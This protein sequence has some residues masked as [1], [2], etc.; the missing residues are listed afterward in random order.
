M[1]LEETTYAKVISGNAKQFP[2]RVAV[3][4]GNTSYTYKELDRI[5]DV[6]AAKIMAMGIEKGDHVALWGYN[7]ANWYLTFVSIIKAGA[8]AVL[9]NYSL[10]VKD[11]AEL[12]SYTDSKFI[13][14]GNNR[15][16]S[17]DLDAAKNLAKLS[18]LSEDKLF[19][20]ADETLDFKK[21]IN[22]DVDV[23]KVTAITQT[24]DT[25]R[26]AV[27]IFTTGTTAT[28]KAVLLSQYGII[29]DGVSYGGKYKEDRGESICNTLP[30]F[31]SF[32]LMVVSLYTHDGRTVY[33]HELIKP[34]EIVKV[35]STYKTPDIA[36]VGAVYTALVEHPEFDI[37]VI[38]YA[39]ICL[40]GGSVSTP[41][42][43]M[44]LEDKFTHAVF[45]NAYG[46]TE[47][48]PAVTNSSPTDPIEKR[49]ASVGSVLEG[50]EVKIWD[51]EKGILKTG[52]VGE[53]VIRGFVVMNGYYK[54]PKDKQPIDE[55]GWLHTGDLGCLDE[56]NFLHLTGRIKDIIIKSGENISPAEIEQKIIEVDCIKEVK[57][58]GAPHPV[59]SESIEACVVL[60]DGKTFDEEE[61]I[62]Y[63]KTKISKFK[64][65]S[66][67]FVFDEFP[68]LGNGKLDARTL[69]SMMLMRL[70]RLR[71][72]R[73]LEKGLHVN[74]TI[75]NNDTLA[76][77]PILGLI[78][79][80]TKEM[81]FTEKRSSEITE[82]VEALLKE[83]ILNAYVDVG[84]ITIQIVLYKD[85]MRVQFS[86][87]GDKFFVEEN[88]VAV[89]TAKTILKNV[90]NYKKDSD[91]KGGS[92]YSLDFNWEDDFNLLD[93]L[94]NK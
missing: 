14:Y 6:Y 92:V 91:P 1:I 86:D 62:S 30:M 21:Y 9:L 25:R 22:E 3:C 84:Q 36:G 8:V 74:T 17:K 68:L 24:D 69:K 83:R 76:I 56:D 51:K 78:G 28:P 49:A 40:I 89:N 93:F 18:G 45:L 75:V 48:S 4:S 58:M 61:M 55:D 60:Y 31:H 39:R 88:E 65:P 80:F 27:I 59:T 12:V 13:F 71:L 70:K 63:L 57:V 23:G 72:E 87:Q 20:Y 50:I 43:L 67:F 52:E 10:P 7:S 11:L 85:C 42:F 16:L 19:N 35:V 54:F 2:D 5:S 73:K 44:R 34:E 53:V 66:H 15:E 46:Q 26:D 32:G 37:K 79:T 94:A 41:A 29:N 47:S 33:L 90:S 77:S 81:R 82:A 64:I 38:P